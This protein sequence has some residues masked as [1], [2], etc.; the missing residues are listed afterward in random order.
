MNKATLFYL[1]A[2][3]ASAPAL[4]S[5]IPALFPYAAQSHDKKGEVE[6]SWSTSINGTNGGMLDFRKKDDLKGQCDNITCTISGEYTNSYSLPKFNRSPFEL[7]AFKKN[8]SSFEAKCS[9]S[10]TIKYDRGEYEKVEAQGSCRLYLANAGDVLIKGDLSAQGSTIIYLD[11]GSYWLDSLK[12]SGNAKIVING[13]G[14]VNFYVK[15][16]VD[17]SISNQVGSPSQKVNIFHYDSDQVKLGDNATWYGDIKSYGDFELQGSSKFY[18]A[19]QAKSLELSG[20]TRLYLDAGT[21]WY[22]EVDLQ[23]SARVIPQ[24]EELT[25]FYIEEDL[26]LQGSTELGTSENPILAFVYGDGDDDGEAELEGSSKIYGY[27]YVEG[28]LEMQGSTKIFGAVNVVD[29]EMEGSS[30]INYSAIP[31]AGGVRHYQLSFDVEA[32]DLTA[33]A[34]GDEACSEALLYSSPA[35][36]HIKD[37]LNNNSISNFDKF[38]KSDKDTNPNTKLDKNKCIQFV[39]KK[40]DPS[41]EAPPGLRCYLSDGTRLQNCKLCTEQ[42]VQSS[43]A[44]Y[45]YDEIT[46]DEEALGEAAPDFDFYIT[47]LNGTGTLKTDNKTLKEG[48]GVSFPLDLTYNK[49]EAISLTIKGDNGDKGKKKREAEYQLDLVFVPK[50]LRWSA[51]DC[52][53]DSGFSYADHATSCAILGKAGEPVGL[54]LQAYGEGDKLIDD[55]S[56]QLKGIVIYELTAKL[57]K[58]REFEQGVFEFNQKSKHSF[59]TASKIASVALIEATVPDS[60]AS[61]AVNNDGNCMLETGGDTTTVGRTVPDRLLVT[62]GSGKLENGIAYRGK[63]VTY[64]RDAQNEPLQLPYFSVTAC[65]AG[66]KD[67]KCELPS[68]TDEF[69]AG[70]DLYASLT[71]E[72]LGNELVW[73]RQ[74]DGT[75]E[76][77]FR[78]D[79]SF[80]F[81]K[82]DPEAE[83]SLHIPLSLNLTAHD[84]LDEI[85]VATDFAGEDDTL[86]FGFIT[87]MDTEIK[88]GEEGAMASKLHYYGENLNTLKE[89]GLTDYTLSF[90]TLDAKLKDGNSLPDLSLSLNDDKVDVAP[91]SSEQKDIEVTIEGLPVWLRPERDGSLSHPEA[92]LD[93]LDQPRRRANDSTFNR[94]E[95]IR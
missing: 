84:Q 95:V 70:L 49:A 13:D 19:V 86:R 15:D 8:N 83:Q 40:A 88:V 79:E 44:A 71:Q 34:C 1:T 29:L 64:H 74:D 60:C 18:G 16:N 85:T 63:E 62:A 59:E 66:Q 22:E 43:L 14:D 26:E 89:D 76:H 87:L 54:T 28:E 77:I 42:D 35:T 12:F 38:L 3:F 69:A 48:S 23:G 32:N 92:R 50:Q 72:L 47:E 33:Y 94:R 53:G 78:P 39:A 56:A 68:Y 82:N 61:Y 36:L 73:Q 67:D 37:G 41:P 51:A 80:T 10:G 31:V 65:A 5:S 2:L 46:L 90:G 75:G 52:G 55:Y 81:A 27:L 30:S 91:Y 4:A 21:Y 57:E 58:T 7:P 11:S 9:G 17:I 93:I 45:V 6:M 25:T 24:G 20:S